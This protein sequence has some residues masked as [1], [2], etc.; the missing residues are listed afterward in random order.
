MSEARKARDRLRK[1]NNPAKDKIAKKRKTDRD[2]SS[3]TYH[4]FFTYN[5]PKHPEAKDELIGI[6]TACCKC[7]GFQLEE[8]DSKTPH[9][10]GN[11][12]L[13]NQTATPSKLVGD[14]HKGIHWERTKNVA[15]AKNYCGKPEGRLD[16][17]WVYNTKTD[18]FK[19]ALSSKTKD[20]AIAI[21]KQHCAKDWCNNGQRIEENLAR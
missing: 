14:K 15:A 20:E 11:V 16:G 4:W 19:I 8:G 5:N 9:Y 7:F 21:I 10:Q 1:A 6:F 13:L 3:E 2:A 12:T 17:P 18:W